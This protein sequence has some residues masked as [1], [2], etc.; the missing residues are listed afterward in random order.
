[1]GLA[2]LLEKCS[3]NGLHAKDIFRIHEFL[4]DLSETL[5]IVSRNE[6]E[7]ISLRPYYLYFNIVI[8]N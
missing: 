5:S 7:V 3:K 1:M 4:K 2:D 6:I 8:K